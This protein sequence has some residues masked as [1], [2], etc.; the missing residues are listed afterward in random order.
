MVP[1]LHGGDCIL[2]A[3]QNVALSSLCLLRGGCHGIAVLHRLR[4]CAWDLLCDVRALVRGGHKLQLVPQSQCA[5]LQNVTRIVSSKDN[6]EVYLYLHGDSKALLCAAMLSKD[7]STI[8]E[9]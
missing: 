2:G 7:S 5:L 6:P 3:L 1:H 9:L 8:I 4:S